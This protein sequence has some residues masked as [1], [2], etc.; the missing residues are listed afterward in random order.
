[1]SLASLPFAPGAPSFQR[2]SS[3]DFGESAHKSL[4]NENATQAKD[5][6]NKRNRIMMIVKNFR[7]LEPEP[8]A[9]FPTSKALG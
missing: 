2:G 9:D 6:D 5:I 3:N 8:L 7:L 1:M 4:E